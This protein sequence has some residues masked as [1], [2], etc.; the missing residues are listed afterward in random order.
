MEPVESG[1]AGQRWQSLMDVAVDRVQLVA[2]EGDGE[3]AECARQVLHSTTAWSRWERELGLALRPVAT[4]RNRMMQIRAL[5]Q[6]SFTWVHRAAPFR[7]MRNQH[8]QGERRRRLVAAL[9]DGQFVGYDRA[10][11][12]EHE[13]WMRSVCHGFCATHLGESMLG[14]PLYRESMRRYQLL[15]MEYFRAFGVFTCGREGKSR[16]L[17]RKMLPMMKSQLAELRKAL[18]QHPLRSDWLQRESLLRKPTG[19]TQELRRLDFNLD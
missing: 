10:L 15:Y 13:S 12:T 5:R 1:S 2:R 18:L 8:V 11:V 17:A 14:D 9:Y 6:A 3:A 4:Y 19:D 16:N 7:Y